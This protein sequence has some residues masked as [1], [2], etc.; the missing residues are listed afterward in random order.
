[1]KNALKI[2]NCFI[3]AD[4]EGTDRISSDS[5]QMVAHLG[6]QTPASA[7]EIGSNFYDHFTFW[8]RN[9]T[10]ED[11]ITFEVSDNTTKMIGF[12]LKPTDSGSSL[13]VKLSIPGQNVSDVKL[14][15]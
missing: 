3:C 9:L 7:K 6:R 15:A 8:T 10:M 14:I 1:M 5:C 13:R 4:C 11:H 12:T 2:R